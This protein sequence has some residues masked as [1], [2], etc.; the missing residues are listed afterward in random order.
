[1]TRHFTA[2]VLSLTL[3]GGS[4]VLAQSRGGSPQELA[5]TR[6]GAPTDETK[7]TGCLRSTSSG[8]ASG[9]QTVAYSLDTTPPASQAAGKPS[10]AGPPAGSQG[11]MRRVGESARAQSYALQA[12]ESVGLSKHVNHRIEVTGRLRQETP[13][14]AAG[15]TA[16]PSPESA[17]ASDPS[18]ASSNQVI[19]VT[20]IRMISASCS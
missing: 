6:Q 10:P 19:E 7:L 17:E 5:H 20:A 3:M 15:R 8:P 11:S 13:T 9:T 16:K 2:S 14:T 1:M 18:A 12:A 4:A